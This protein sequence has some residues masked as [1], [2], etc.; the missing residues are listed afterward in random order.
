MKNSIK[1]L[2]VVGLVATFFALVSCAH[3]SSVNAKKHWTYSNNTLASERTNDIHVLELN[4][5][6]VIRVGETVRVIIPSDR[7]FE[8]GT[9]NL[10]ESGYLANTA[11]FISTL[12]TISIKV[13]AYSDTANKVGAPGERKVALTSKQAEVVQSYLWSKGIDSRFIYAKGYGAKDAVAWNGTTLGRSFNRRVEI[14]FNF[15]PF[16]AK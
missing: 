6:K 13:S 14:S 8:P 9:A 2:K 10:N 16:L 7:L 3:N 15:Y 1:L 11:H 12:N 5:A 4:G